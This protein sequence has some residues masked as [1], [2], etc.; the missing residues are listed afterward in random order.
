M[1]DLGFTPQ[2]GGSQPQALLTDNVHA[3]QQRSPIQLRDLVH[4]ANATVG[5]LDVGSTP[6]P[7]YDSL[8]YTATLITTKCCH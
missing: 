5:R 7:M 2:I 6:I 4:D 1:T 3:S 8:H